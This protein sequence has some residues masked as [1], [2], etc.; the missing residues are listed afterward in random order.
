MLCSKQSTGYI[1]K[2]PLSPLIW[3]ALEVQPS[4]AGTEFG[5]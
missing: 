2:K 1:F 5:R 3:T 4:L